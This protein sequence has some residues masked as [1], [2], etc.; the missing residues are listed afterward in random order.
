MSEL[1][2]TNR[3]GLVLSSRSFHPKAQSC[4]TLTRSSG[5]ILQ[6]LTNSWRRSTLTVSRHVFLKEESESDFLWLF[7]AL[8]ES[9]SEGGVSDR[10]RRD[11]ETEPD[12][13]T[14]PG[15]TADGGQRRCS[16]PELDLP[17]RETS[18][19]CPICQ[20]SFPITEIEVHAAYC[21]GEESAAADRRPKPSCHEGEK[22]NFL[23]FFYLLVFV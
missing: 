17:V 10:G 2:E 14:D 22:Q 15:E 23:G 7:S 4:W 3:F 12:V 6:L 19:D 5:T 18:V 16:S 21:D 8:L 1:S 20:R 13:G 11:E 9:N